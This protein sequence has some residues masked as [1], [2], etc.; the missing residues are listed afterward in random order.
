MNR[1][2]CQHALY[3]LTIWQHD[4]TKDIERF[5]INGLYAYPISVPNP[6]SRANA[7]EEQRP[8]LQLSLHP[9]RQNRRTS[10][11]RV[12][13]VSNR[14]ASH[15]SSSSRVCS[16]E[17]WTIQSLWYCQ[18]DREPKSASSPH[19]L[20]PDYPLSSFRTSQS[21]SAGDDAYSA[22]SRYTDT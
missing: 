19:L 12:F 13:H 8:M 11:A 18:K 3:Y 7:W 17:M 16:D 2:S 9:V 15:S 4:I 6:M 14:L 5:E 21:W 10:F 1:N 20:M 22:T